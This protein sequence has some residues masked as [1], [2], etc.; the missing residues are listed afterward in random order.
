MRTHTTLRRSL[1]PIALALAAVVI[2][3]AQAL[4]K[5][6]IR[7]IHAVPG[8]GTASVNL[9]TGTGMHPV[10]SVGFGQVSGWVSMRAGSCKWALTSGGK[11]LVHGTATLGDGA[12]DIVVLDKRSGVSLGVY[13]VQ[14]GRPGSSLVRVIHAAPELGSPELTLDS[15]VADKSLSFTS[16]TPYL[17]VTPGAHV[18]RGDQAGNEHRARA[19]GRE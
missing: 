12:Y 18:A 5:A 2:I 6:V 3:P 14:A 11:L 13:R 10:G 4:G 19:R 17:S 16:A 1:A 7:F 9:D 15:K 8:V